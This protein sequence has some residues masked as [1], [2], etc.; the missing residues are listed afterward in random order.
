MTVT[1]STM[2][3]WDAVR[4]GFPLSLATPEILAQRIAGIYG[5][6]EQ[7]SQRDD[8]AGRD[9]IRQR[10]GMAMGVSIVA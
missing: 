2:R 5:E 1:G 8:A 6:Y 4:R 9:A 10:Y 7:R 3:A